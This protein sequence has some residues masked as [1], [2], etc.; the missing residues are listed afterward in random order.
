MSAAREREREKN[1]RG[2]ERK[3]GGWV[4]AE[5]R[6]AIVASG[7]TAPPGDVINWRW[8]GSFNILKWTRLSRG[9]LLPVFIALESYVYI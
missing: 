9:D 8:R 4:P 3:M 6:E 5:G 2:R 1:G 7:Y